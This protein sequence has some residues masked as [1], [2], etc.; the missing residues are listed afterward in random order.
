M[1][2]VVSVFW[3]AG[4]LRRATTGP[5]TVTRE[6]KEDTGGDAFSCCEGWMRKRGC[7]SKW[8]WNQGDCAYYDYRCWRT[9]ER[10]F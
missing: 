5:G 9:S 8:D 3:V 6:G 10:R 2:S 4:W 1:T 7:C